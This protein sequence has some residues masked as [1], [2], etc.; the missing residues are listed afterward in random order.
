MEQHLARLTKAGRIGHT[1][2]TQAG[3]RNMLG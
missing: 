1:G 2:T 3:R